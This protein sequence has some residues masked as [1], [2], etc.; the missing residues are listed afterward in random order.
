M[1]LFLITLLLLCLVHLVP[2]QPAKQY[3]FTQFTTADGLPSNLVNSI[4]QDEEGFLWFATING[5]T[6]YDG[7][8][9]LN[10]LTPR[11]S[12]FSFA[13]IAVLYYDKT[14]NIWVVTADSKVGV[15]NPVDFTFREV[16]A[17]AMEK[18]A[19]R[20]IQFLETVDGTFL[21][22]EYMGTTYR[23]DSAAN[24]LV[25]DS[26]F[27][28]RP[29]GWR[30]TRI[31]WDPTDKRYWIGTD[32]GLVTYNPSIKQ[33]SYRGHNVE[34]HPAIERYADILNVLYVMVDREKNLIFHNWPPTSASPF[35]HC[36]LR[37]TGADVTFDLGIE[38]GV[39]YHELGECLQQRNGR[40]WVWGHPVLAEWL[41]DRKQ[42][43]SIMNDYRTEQSIRFD[44]VRTLFEDGERNVW[45]ATDNGLYFFNPDAQLFANYNFVHPGEKELHEYPATS[46]LQAQ[47]STVYVS[48]W[49]T[50]LFMYDNAL[51]P[52]P[53]PKALDAATAKNRSV[54]DM[55]QHTKTGNIWMTLQAGDLVVY[56][57]NTKTTKSY[58]PEIFNRRTIRQVVEDKD[59]NLWFGTHAGTIIKWDYQQSGGNPE[60]GYTLITKAGMVL[61]MTV[62]SHGFVWAATFAKGLLQLDTRHN[63]VVQVF[64]KDTP[65]G[66]LTDNVVT[67]VLQ[68][69]DSLMIAI[70]NSLNIINLNTNKVR[71]ITTAEGLP[72]NTAVCI[73]RDQIGMLWVGMQNGLCR[74]NLQKGTG[75]TYDRRNGI[76]YDNFN[77]AGAFRLLNGRIAYTTDH[78]FLVFNPK[79]FSYASTVPPDP[80]F[81]TITVS[82]KS[83]A[84]DS[85]LTI[86][87]LVL[88]YNNNSIAFE[89][90]VLSFLKQKQPD[91]VYIL[92][93]FDKGWVQTAG[94][95]RAVYSYLPPGDYRF[96]VK[97]INQDGV[98]SKGLAELEVIV[99]PPFWR[100]W[101]FYGF[102][103]LFGI[104]MLFLIDKERQKRER[105]LQT[106]RTQI[107]GDLHEEI[108]TTLNDINLL[109]EIAKIK[110]DKDI[111]RSKDYIDQI[112][113]KSRTMIESMDDILWSIDPENDSMERMLLRIHEFTDG[114]Q[115]SSDV[116]VEL[117][118]DEEVEGLMLDMKTRH[119]FLLFYKDALVYVVQHSV[120]ST[121]YIS[122][123]YLRGKLS[124]KLLAQCNQTDESSP[125][126]T[127]LEYGMQRRADA[128][129]GL[130]DIISDRKSVSI[131]LQ[132]PV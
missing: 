125:Q 28:P 54:W 111:D 43:A 5:L 12:N 123:E 83:L 102:I 99:K 84:V 27:I 87:K 107:A 21:L 20:Q 85:L 17:K 91:Y 96:K 55:L 88:P 50:G 22:Q 82:G 11:N 122:M 128:L 35:L 62:D 8:R 36:Y 114:I 70:T 68:Y 116:K 57:P 72:S 44:Y 98:F 86:G 13:N 24:K 9:F 48:T 126:L 106:V 95:N 109:S 26:T 64:T 10:F 38:L 46:V 19:Y 73:E 31:A 121:I 101:W 14:H 4:A 74:I 132:V 61:K 52:I 6:R 110:A 30:I 129:N 71:H 112:S 16:D 118:V 66:S 18:E 124:L 94:T 67:D 103:T 104:T 2:A 108:N 92:E 32:S 49:G 119:E 120:C 100:T 80:D 53:V 56:N 93:R 25:P 127:Q 89:F 65:G 51:N 97:A 7:Y 69:N 117:T 1:R 75:I 47:D 33:L 58:A 29:K 115:K 77:P 37:N 78:N 45:V 60:V 42:F 59:G 15:F 3:A 39:G 41:P 76:A 79:D 130:L 105:A 34:R 131:I 81:S 90:S 23:L 113:T 63:M 40:L